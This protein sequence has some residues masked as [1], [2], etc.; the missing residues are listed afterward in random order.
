MFIFIY[1]YV[2]FY[3]GLLSHKISSLLGHLSDYFL[4]RC[5]TFSGEELEGDIIENEI[6]QELLPSLQGNVCTI[7][8]V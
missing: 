6:L 5:T 3:L 2:I 1:I 4:T 7:R 8:G